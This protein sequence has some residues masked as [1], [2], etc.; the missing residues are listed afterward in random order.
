M[1]YFWLLVATL[2]IELAMNLPIGSLPLVLEHDGAARSQIAMAMGV[3]MVTTVFVALP[4][5]ALVDRVGRILTM[6][7][8]VSGTF[9]TLT[10]LWL[11]HGAIWGGLLMGTRSILMIAFMAAQAAYIS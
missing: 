3:G 5:G 9:V 7:L 11:T 1:T 6:K 10:L 4:I 8:A 2:L